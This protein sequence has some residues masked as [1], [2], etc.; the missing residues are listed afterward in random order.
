MCQPHWPRPILIG[1]QNR[2]VDGKAVKEPMIHIDMDH[3]RVGAESG[4]PIFLP[5]GGD[6]PYLENIMQTLQV[7]HQG[8]MVDEMF[9]SALDSMELF[10]PVNIEISLSNI[11]TVNLRDYYTINKDKLAQLDGENLEKLNKMGALSLIFCALT[12]QGNFN[13]LI[14]L[15]NKKMAI[16]Q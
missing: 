5:Y 3:P 14:E 6:S 15:K 8:A 10:E 4:Q 12:S 11:E 16:A 2:E 7:I 9:F 1:F 13:K